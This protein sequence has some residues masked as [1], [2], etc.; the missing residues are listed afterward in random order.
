MP[1]P[2]S[3]DHHLPERL[4]SRTGYGSYWSIR[5]SYRRVTERLPAVAWRMPRD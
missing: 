2:A 3:D 5:A 4:L 1:N